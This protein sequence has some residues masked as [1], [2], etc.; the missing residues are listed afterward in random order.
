MGLHINS[1]N[2]ICA[3]LLTYAHLVHNACLFLLLM[4]ICIIWYIIINL[5]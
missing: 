2:T 5:N 4:Y 3:Q 1:T